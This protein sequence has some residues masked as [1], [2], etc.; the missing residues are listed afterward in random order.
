MTALTML[1][2]QNG[3]IGFY[4]EGHSGYDDAGQ[5]I[6]CASISTAT[7]FCVKYLEKKGISHTLT[8]RE[9]L[10]ECKADRFSKEFED[11]LNILCDLAEDLAEEYPEFIRFE[12]MEA[13][14]NE[15]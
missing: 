10:I 3:L 2:D 8:V 11:L 4:C 13:N 7:Q 6:V 5:D 9:A 1:K 15:I 14:G 12:I